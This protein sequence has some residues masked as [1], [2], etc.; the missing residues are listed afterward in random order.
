MKPLLS[1]VSLFLA[2]PMMAQ[3][4]LSPAEKTMM[5]EIRRLEA[6]VATLE[7]RLAAPPTAAV[8]VNALVTQPAAGPVSLA[9][10]QLPGPLA[11]TTINGTFDGYYLFNFNRPIGRDNLLRVYDVTSNS[12]SLNQADLIVEN[13][14]DPDH[15]KRWGA[16]IDLQ[17][18]QATQTLQGN[19]ANEPRP[20]IYRNIFQAYGTYVFPVGRGLTVDF[21]KWSSS[22][23]IEGNYS[24]DQMNYSRSFLFGALPFYHMGVRAAY[25]VNDA[26]TLNYW[27]DN[28]VQQTEAFNDFKDE[29]FGLNIT[30]RKNINW[31]VNYYL[32]QEHPDV[33]FFNG[34]ANNNPP[35][36]VNLPTLQGVPFLPIP[37]PPTGRLN[38]FDSYVSWQVSPR[39]QLALEGDYLINRLDHN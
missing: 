24:K 16:R 10:P 29:L 2:W 19:P 12:F 22:L 6:R 26:F 33:V 23:G 21:G 9:D 32:G 15:G 5:E 11:G 18:G 3:D 20:E 38:I 34:L 28:G 35:V 17:F 37:N 1:I 25:K 39:L 4:Q 36:G 7:A 13:A 30:P 27:L 31:T 14:P 8:P